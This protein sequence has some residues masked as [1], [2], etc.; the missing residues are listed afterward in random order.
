MI[1]PSYSLVDI[2]GEIADVSNSTT[3]SLSLGFEGT[4]WTVK[5]FNPQCPRVV[6]VSSFGVVHMG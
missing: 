6:L 4:R 5:G 2:N 1:A 3:P